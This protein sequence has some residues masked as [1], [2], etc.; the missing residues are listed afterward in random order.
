MAYDYDALYRETP[1]ALGLPSRVFTD[2]FEPRADAG[3]RVLDLGCGQGRDALFIARAGHRVV[4]VDLSPAGI[5]DM[6]RVA[7][8]EGLDVTGI[9]ADIAQFEPDGAFDVVL[10]DRTLH[11]LGAG[12]R[13]A[14]LARLAGHVVPGG[15]LLIADEPRN[16]AAL[17]V[18]LE[19]PDADWEITKAQRGLLFARRG[20]S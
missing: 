11:M 19:T 18:A 6:T 12:S 9:V 20:A 17:R 14:V 13:H 3:L 7:R 5:A 8:A 15:W 10:I 1:D 16:I 4:G 2:W